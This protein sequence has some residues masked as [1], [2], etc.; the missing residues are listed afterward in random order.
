MKQLIRGTLFIGVGLLAVLLLSSHYATFAAQDTDGYYTESMLAHL[1][2]GEPN[3]PE[4]ESLGAT[5]CDGG[6][7]GSYPCDGIDLLARIPISSLGGGGGNDIWGWT[8][9]LDGKEYAIVGR[10]NGTAFVD[11]SNP[12][13]PVYLGNLPSSATSN[14][15]RD[16]KT[17]NNHAFI[18]SEIYNHGMQ[19]FDLTRLR[20]V[21]APPVTFTEDARY[22]GISSAH[23]VVINEATGYAYTVGGSSCG[24]GGLEM[25]DISTPTSP[26]YVGCANSAGYTHDAQCIVYDGPDMDHKGSEICFAYND[27]R[28]AIYDVTD[29]SSPVELAALSYAGNV[30]AHQGWVTEDHEYLLLDDE[31]D[32]NTYGHDTKTYIWDIRDLDTPVNFANYFGPNPSTDHN[33]YILGDYS[34]QSNYTSGLQVLDV[35]D[36]ANGNLSQVAFFDTWSSSNSAGYTGQWSNYPY[37]DSGIII[38]NGDG[39]FFI[40]Q[41]TFNEPV[42]S[43]TLTPMSIADGDAGETVT[44]SFTLMNTGD[45]DMYTVAVSGETWN[46]TLLTASPV[47][48]TGGDSVVIEVEVDI[49]AVPTMTEDMFTLTV[50]SVND[51][52]VELMGTG[53]TTTEELSFSATLTPMS[54]A[55]DEPGETVMHSFTLMNTGDDDMYSL[56]VS[57]ET[58]GTTLLTASPVSVMGGDSVVI[59]VEVDIPM[60]LMMSEDSFTLT[61]TSINDPTV[62]LMATGTTTTFM[63]FLYLPVIALP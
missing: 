13:N 36:V 57:G 20:N 3:L 2:E 1:A 18:V 35:T 7:A 44:H 62:E 17:Y 48:V 5:P 25:I 21:V 59:E 37:F 23:N 31:I 10:T 56:A 12:L 28:L 6:M 4:G 24:N 42:Y 32:E 14:T 43:A 40:L 46:T 58:W 15:W 9:P 26:T 50:T 54:T 8:D 27:D 51:P 61:A 19:V 53:T 33:Q 34:Y 41:P 38:T 52:L 60:S 11:V 49:P 16:I 63:N 47:S 30:Y 55:D 39:G 45:D 22:T 29:K